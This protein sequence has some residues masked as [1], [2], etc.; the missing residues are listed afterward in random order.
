VKI[1]KSESELKLESCIG[2]VPRTV[3]SI[4]VQDIKE[5]LWASLKDSSGKNE[6]QRPLG[7]YISPLCMFEPNDDYKNLS[8]TDT[9]SWHM[10]TTHF[11]LSSRFL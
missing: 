9:P 5:R 10:Q 4:I 2:C 8:E 3:T 6:P 1:F 7:L 11:L